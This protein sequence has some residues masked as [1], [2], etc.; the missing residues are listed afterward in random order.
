[1]VQWV[2]RTTK[3]PDKVLDIKDAI[4]SA[5]ESFSLAATFAADLVETTINING[6]QFAQSLDIDDNFTRFRKMKYLKRT[7]QKGYICWIDSQNVFD[8]HGCEQLDR[9][10]RAGGNI[11]FK[12]RVLSPTLD[13]GYYSYPGLLVADTDDHWMMEVIKT[14]VHDKAAARVFYL[15]GEN[16]DADK[17]GKL[18]E[19][20]FLAA[21]DDLEDSAEIRS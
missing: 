1:M 21:R 6:T 9:W 16:S 19:N 13:I 3:R 5:I 17:F 18:A 14:I 12:M 10:Y 11:V 4:N 20:A 2:M 8:K 15:I 7:G